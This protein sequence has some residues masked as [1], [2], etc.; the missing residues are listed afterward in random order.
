MSG[1]TSLIVVGAATGAVTSQDRRTLPTQ[2]EDQNIELKAVRALFKNK[3]LWKDT[4]INV[5]SFN[6]T[7]LIVGQ[8][9]TATLKNTINEEIKKIAKVLKVYNQIR[10][11]APIGFFSRRSDDILTTKIKS[12]MLFTDD[13][14]VSKIKV[15]SE[16]S[17]V[18]LMGLVTQAEAEKAAEVARNVS[19][20][21]KVIKVFEY[22]EQEDEMDG[23]SN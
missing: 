11:M 4:N 15:V 2:L 14:P 8:S 19:G 5:I 3:A 18:F 21:T 1:C 9:P 22:I 17:E 7:V 20:V 12:S 6:N 23:E 16:N 13:L 10:I